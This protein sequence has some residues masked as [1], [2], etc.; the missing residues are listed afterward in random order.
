MSNTEHPTPNREKSPGTRCL[1]NPCRN[2]Q[3]CDILPPVAMLCVATLKPPIQTVLCCAALFLAQRRF[4][5]AARLKIATL[6][7]ELAH[8]PVG[9]SLFD[10]RHWI[11]AFASMSNTEHPTPNREKSPGTR[12][13]LN[14]CRNAQR[15]DILPPV[16]MLCVATLQPPPA[17]IFYND[18]T[19]IAFV[20]TIMGSSDEFILLSRV[21]LGESQ[22]SDQCIEGLGQLFNCN[23]CS[24]RMVLAS[25]ISP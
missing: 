24:P 4:F 20:R 10:I 13:L 21:F 17:A 16:A 2:A 15:C 9:H 12:C 22:Y 3:R 8:L 14:P 23:H 11:F 19:D 6:I 18:W 5:T 7:I 1:L 25:S